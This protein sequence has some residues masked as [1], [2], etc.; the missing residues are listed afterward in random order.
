MEEPGETQGAIEDFTTAIKVEHRF[1]D[2]FNNRGLAKNDLLR[3]H[4]RH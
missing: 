2:A 1:A 4:W 3:L